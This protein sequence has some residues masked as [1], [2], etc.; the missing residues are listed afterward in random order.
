MAATQQEEAAAREAE[1]EKQQRKA[2]SRALA[3]LAIQKEAEL[4]VRHR[5]GWQ[6]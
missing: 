5:H 4:L 2:A 6:S 3:G 1:R